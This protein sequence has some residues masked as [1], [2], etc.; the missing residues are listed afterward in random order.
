MA[1]F[2]EV[3]RNKNFFSL[4]LGQIISQLGDRLHQMAL[5]GFIAQRSPGK[6]LQLAILLSFTILPVFVVGP[7]AGVY[8]DRW[9]RR[10]TMYI[11]DFLRGALVL[12]IPLYL[13][14]SN[15]SLLPLYFVVFLLF[16]IGRFFVPAK[17]AIV[18]ELIPKEQLL[19]ANSL[20]NTTGM[21][22]ATAGFGIGG[23]VVAVLG[24][25]GGFYIDSI[26]FFLSSLLIFLIRTSSKHKIGLIELSKEIVEVI[27]KSVLSEIKE[28][29]KYLLSQ[30]QMRA[31]ISIL[32]LVW[33]A[34]GAI[35]IVLIVFVQDKLQSPTLGL[36]LLV[37]FLGLGLFSGSLIYGRFGRS[38]NC[39]K[40]I[41]SS[42]L[43][44]GL[45][46]S[47]FAYILGR[48]AHFH[49]AA[50]SVFVFG[51][52]VAPI[53]TATNTLIQNIST[54][55]MLGKVFSSIELVMHMAFL[56]FMFLGSSL[57]EFKS[58]GRAGLLIAVGILFAF[59]GSIGLLKYKYF[60][61]SGIKPE[62]ML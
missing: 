55:E 39:F 13:I 14:D 11:C 21:I 15:M 33:A 2:R 62:I 12:L 18:P 3:L 30:K 31:V 26:S 4:W 27:K 60:H 42:L 51:L 24:V 29:L 56:L 25:K 44:S 49:I 59:I 7:I 36:G 19:L 10:K 52:A 20:V 61:F 38:T 43:T 45:A 35:Y 16:S 1:R 34:L 46:L 54:K 48:S 6:T 23:I 47:A 50:A 58:I 40:T 9:D 8:V 37:V 22:A 17:L 41:F 28:G 5:I 53:M 57:A 32:F